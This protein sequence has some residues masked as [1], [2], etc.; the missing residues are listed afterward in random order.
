MR[1]AW[2]LAVA[3]LVATT[4]RAEPPGPATDACTPD[5]A[6]ARQAGEVLRHYIEYVGTAELDRLDQAEDISGLRETHRRGVNWISALSCDAKALAGDER[7]AVA[8]VA[9]SAIEAAKRVDAAL[10]IED[11][12]EAADACMA[13]RVCEAI[14]TRTDIGAQIRRERA[15]PGG[16][17]NLKL[18]H[19][20]GEQAQALDDLIAARK[21]RFVSA[22]KKPFAASMCKP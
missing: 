6:K 2:C 7:R 3:L 10:K 4:A 22:R 16:V 1:A 20:L 11:S 18:L 13:A 15:N 9:L 8:A 14:A 5:A 12:C 17:V 21:K 19:D